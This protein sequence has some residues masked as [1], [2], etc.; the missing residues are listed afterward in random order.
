MDSHDE[1]IRPDELLAQLGWVRALARSLVFDP[2]MTDDVLQQVCVLALQKAPRDARTGP[3]LRAWLAAVTRSLVRRSARADARRVRR[4]QAAAQ[5]EALPSTSDIAEHRDALRKLIDAVTG[6]EEPYFSAIVARYFEG[7]SVADIAARHAISPAAVR[8][9]LSR[10]KSQLRARL[11]QLLADDRDGWL[12][13]ALP[14]APAAASIG[15]ARAR[16]VFD[17]ARGFFMAKQ[18]GSGSIAKV[19]VALVIA[20]GLLF[21]TWRGFSVSDGARAAPAIVGRAGSGDAATTTGG[22]L[23]AAAAPGDVQ[24]L[25]A[26]AAPPDPNAESL[27]TLMVR[28]TWAEDGT[29]A[30]DV[31]FRVVNFGVADPLFSDVFA[32]SGADGA[33]RLDHVPVGHVTV[34]VDRGGSGDVDVTPGQ[35]TEMS[36]AIPAGTLVHG[37]VVDGAGKPM[38][39]AEIWLAEGSRAYR[40]YKG[41]LAA[42]ADDNGRFT[43]RAVSKRRCVGAR[44]RGHEASQLTEILPGQH[45]ETA[46]TLVVGGAVGSVSGVVR[47]PAGEP[48]AGAF[49]LVQSGPQEQSISDQ[50][51]S[52]S[53]LP[54]ACLTDDS[55]RFGARDVATGRAWITVRSIQFSGWRQTVDVKADEEFRLDVTLQPAAVLFGVVHDAHGLPVGGAEIGTGYEVGRDRGYESSIGRRI[56]SSAADGRFELVGLDVAAPQ[57]DVTASM[58]GVVHARTTLKDVHAGDRVEWNP[59][60]GNELTIS[61]TLQD[62]NGT[63]V[64]GLWICGRR[65]LE[66]RLCR[67]ICTSDASGRFELPDC[68]QAKYLLTVWDSESP[69]SVP[70][71]SLDGVMAG[72]RDISI[73]VPA[74]ARSTARITGHITDAQGRAVPQLVAWVLPMPDQVM[75]SEPSVDVDT[76]AMQTDL[77]PP[78]NYDLLLMAP[79][80]TSR[81][82][83]VNDVQPHEVRDIGPIVMLRT[84]TLVVHEPMSQSQASGG[85]NLKGSFAILPMKEGSTEFDG[86]HQYPLAVDPV[87]GVTRPTPLGPGQYLLV[88]G[89]KGVAQ[90]GMPFRIE[91]GCETSL[92]VCIAAG[93]AFE[94]RFPTPAAASG[95]HSIVEMRLSILDKQGTPVVLQQWYAGLDKS[96]SLCLA[97]GDYSACAQPVRAQDGTREL[98]TPDLHVAADGMPAVVVLPLE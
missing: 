73:T 41:Q 66:D 97:P 7:L 3:R 81:T 69:T 85:P 49:V 22:N 84:G 26:S 64:T 58:A 10:A 21:V 15:S 42:H 29:P 38:G 63:P 17:R 31:A 36:I 5:R 54:E 47:N 79:D 78:G 12:R 1:S 24:P 91:P 92:D 86:I 27:G 9:R 96:I 89:G 88:V 13:A 34:T 23:V 56:V 68:E 37:A 93:V 51:A 80:L 48:V 62:E 19:V 43:L 90:Q 57:E 33:W 20:A 39:E 53:A 28:L 72:S 2:D 82:I 11:E 16:F 65:W 30:A 25:V 55:G 87:T 71:A 77:L 61:G 76:G 44:A 50:L 75:N 52:V 8:Q 94:A 83:H 40:P 32:R 6:L 59:V 18:T 45:G 95:K 4:E 98:C 60:F 74:A 67:L 14:A 70:V 35:T 46:V